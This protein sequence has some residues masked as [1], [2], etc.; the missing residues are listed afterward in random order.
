MSALIRQNFR[1]LCTTAVSDGDTF[2]RFEDIMIATGLFAVI[3]VSCVAYAAVSDLGGLYIPNAI[4]L[5]LGAAFLIYAPLFSR[6]MAV[7]A[8]LLVALAMFVLLL[9]LFKINWMGGGDVKLMTAILLWMGPPLAL[10]F[11]LV[12]A[13]WGGVFALALLILQKLFRAY[14]GFEARFPVPVVAAW[15]RR[16]IMPYGVAIAVAALALTPAV[17]RL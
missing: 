5:I 15:A 17:F 14:P 10:K 1:E 2:A 8:H 9:V 6:D 12:M 11:L 7:G 3:F 13:L 16:G 4:S